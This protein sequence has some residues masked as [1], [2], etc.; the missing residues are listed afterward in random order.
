MAGEVIVYGCPHCD[1]EDGGLSLDEII[2]CPDLEGV[3]G[4]GL[5]GKLCEGM[6]SDEAEEE[7]ALRA[8][9]LQEV[10]GMDGG[11]FD[12]DVAGE[13]GGADLYGNENYD[14]D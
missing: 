6:N 13:I 8:H 4:C 7:R 9:D 10:M 3:K 2:G 12:P 5:T 11:D 14:A 1:D